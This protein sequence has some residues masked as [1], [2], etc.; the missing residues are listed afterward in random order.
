MKKKYPDNIESW[1]ALL[2]NMEIPILKVTHEKII[3]LQ[4]DINSI[5]L[6][7]L[8]VLIRH[9]PLLSIKLLKHQENKRSQQQV[10]D[11]TTI[12]KV[13]LMIGL[14]GFFR[15]FGGSPHLEDALG[16]NLA[17]IDACH[18]TCA[19]AYFASQLADSMSKYRRDI[20][21]NEIVT[22]AL[23]H[24]TAEIILWQIAPELMNEIN[25]A[26]KS[27]SN[28]RSKEIQHKI[29]GC[30]INELQQRL[31]SQW[32]LPRILSHLANEN[33]SEEPRV[34]L[35]QLATSI[36]RHTELT[37]NSNFIKEDLKNCADLLKIDINEAHN[38]ITSTAIFAAKQW[39]WYGA[40][41]AVARILES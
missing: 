37:W 25:E 5:D 39:R 8:S 33:F 20:D 29:L 7:D 26:L 41:P 27:N 17:A 21:P 32:N 36:A 28:I 11:V 24:E 31:C 12:E 23:L 18:Q 34:M 2:T 4:Q 35:V 15:A 14:T 9:D 30:S 19:R 13:L 3:E 22:A 1:L 38:L 6:R 16:H 10:T 40:Q